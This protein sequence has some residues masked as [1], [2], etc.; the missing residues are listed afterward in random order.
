M[1]MKDSEYNEKVPMIVALQKSTELFNKK[2]YDD[3]IVILEKVLKNDPSTDLSTTIRGDVW[4]NL[5]VLYVLNIQ[6]RKAFEALIEYIPFTTVRSYYQVTFFQ[7]QLTE[8]Q[9]K[10][11]KRNFKFKSYSQFLKSSKYKK[12]FNKF[13]K[14]LESIF[15]DTE[16]LINKEEFLEAK[17][18]LNFIKQIILYSNFNAVDIMS[19]D[20]TFENKEFYNLFSKADKLAGKCE[21]KYMQI[22]GNILEEKL[23][24]IEKLIDEGKHSEAIEMLN[25]F[26]KPI[27]INSFSQTQRKAE[28]KLLYQSHEIVRRAKDLLKLAQDKQEAE[29]PEEKALREILIH[30]LNIS[31]NVFSLAIHPN[32]KYLASGSEEI[33]ILD[34]ET[35]KLVKS[36]KKRRK[37]DYVHSIA[38]SSDGKYIISGDRNYNLTLFDF[39]S[40]EI[41]WS[42]EENI[43]DIHS[44]AISPDN[45]YVVCGLGRGKFGGPPWDSDVIVFELSSGK[46][47]HTLVGHKEPVGAIVISS[48]SQFII[49]GAMDIKIWDLTS[50][51]LVKNLEVNSCINSLII[52]PE[53][54][55]FLSASSSIKIWEMST[56]TKSREISSEGGTI[57]ALAVSPDCKYIVGGSRWSE[58]LIYEY[59]SGKLIKKFRAHEPTI[60]SIV[61]SND[62]KYLISGAGDIRDGSIKFWNF[63]NIVKQLEREEREEIKK[64]EEL[65]QK[66]IDDKKQKLEEMRETFE[67]EYKEIETQVRA[68]N[69]IDVV[70]S[71]SNVSEISNITV[72]RNKLISKMFDIYRKYKNHEEFNQKLTDII[73][74]F[75]QPYFEINPLEVNIQY[76]SMSFKGLIQREIIRLDN[77]IKDNEDLENLYNKLIKIDFDS[78]IDE[79]LRFISKEVNEINYDVTVESMFNF[80]LDFSQII[81]SAVKTDDSTENEYTL[82]TGWGPFYFKILEKELNK[83]IEYEYDFVADNWGE[84]GNFSIELIEPSPGKVVIRTRNNLQEISEKSKENLLITNFLGQFLKTYIDLSI[85]KIVAKQ[86]QTIFYEKTFDDLT[87][88]NYRILQAKINAMGKK[89]ADLKNKFFEVKAP[90]TLNSF[91]CSE[92]GATLNITSKEEKFIICEHCN[93]PFLMEWQRE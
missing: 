77:I 56:W 14:E 29:T 84:K 73:L 81:P 15:T 3:A 74:S 51:E 34:L 63:P 92:C 20:L 2:K 32:G 16:I 90:L 6:F 31:S 41:L 26:L 17:E 91:N 65:K 57:E 13:L 30:S 43:E 88:G 45:K 58:I 35:F 69:L 64:E 44:V 59:A 9:T 82:K 24:S 22:I 75:Y 38:I 72:N 55:K 47:I 83:K 50:G 25:E 11:L 71:I 5:S 42:I 62:G 86:I 52:S 28:E 7:D 61:F 89:F 93:T 66:K 19:K 67:E 78:F 12:S 49:S 76:F 53:G 79:K 27:K 70:E 4:F 60:N 37:P 80:L 54:N 87:M 36:L 33:L 68:L 40:G 8:S 46:L 48:D 21:S 85:G 23:S 18:R 1:I 39:T 10:A